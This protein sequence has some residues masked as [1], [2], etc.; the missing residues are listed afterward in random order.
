MVKRAGIISGGNWIVDFVKLIDVYPEE[1]ALA[2]ILEEKTGSGGAP[3]NLLKALSRMRVPIPLQGVGIVGD[4]EKGREVVSQCKEMGIDYS[5]LK[6]RPGCGTSY[7]DVMT[8]ADS[9]RRT[10]FHYRGASAYLSEED[11]DF[12]VSRAKIFHLGYLL[13]LDEL[14]RVDAGGRSGASRVLEAAIREGF[15]TSVDIVSEQSERYRSVVPPAL[16]FVDIFFLNELEAK[17]LTGVEI[18]DSEGF[19]EMEKVKEAARYILEMGVRKW[20]IFHFPA[21]AIAF[22][23]DGP[24]VYQPCVNFPKQLIRGTVGAGDAFA[25]GVLAAIHEGWPVKDSLRSGVCVAAMSLLS[26]GASEGIPSWDECLSF[27]EKWGF[28]QV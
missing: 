14:D 7:T 21:G 8:V 15:L 2:N 26:P 1:N 23:K 20:V 5:Q 13:L 6:V 3:F 22:E 17:G 4:D 28:G 9:G 24:A 10:F 12:S 19:P 25:A 11:F 27:G 18:L 16:R